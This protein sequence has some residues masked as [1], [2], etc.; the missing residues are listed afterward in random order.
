MPDYLMRNLHR[1][2][3]E[4]AYINPTFEKM[5]TSHILG[6]YMTNSCFPL[7]LAI[8]GPR[9]EGKTFQTLYSCQKMGINVYYVSGAE[10]SGSFEADSV[11]SIEKSRDDA[12]QRYRKEGQLS[13][14]II[15]DFHLSVA[16][17]DIGVSKTVN[18]QL[19]TGWMMNQADRAMV[20]LRI[21]F[22]LLG[23]TM[24][25]FMRR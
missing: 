1:V 19:L 21:P 20:G 11:N 15:D 25:T 4:L 5:V 17:V 8:H 13:V 14:F 12:I 16:S 2:E 23:M 18:S 3:A 10:L 6:N 7:Y 22:I 24:L 9:G